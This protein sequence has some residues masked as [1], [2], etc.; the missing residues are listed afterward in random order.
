MS[1]ERVL[2]PQGIVKREQQIDG[3]QEKQLSYILY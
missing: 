1:L 2:D 3:S